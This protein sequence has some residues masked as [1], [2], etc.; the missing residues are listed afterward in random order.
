MLSLRTRLL[1]CRTISASFSL[2]ARM[3]AVLSSMAPVLS[4]SVG[5]GDSGAG[6][7]LLEPVE[8]LPE[9]PELVLSF[10]GWYLAS[11]SFRVFS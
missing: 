7:G 2:A 4:G 5:A 10:L 8:P 11:S 6:S 9:P 3:A 1:A